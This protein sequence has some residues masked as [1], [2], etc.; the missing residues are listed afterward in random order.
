MNTRPTFEDRIYERV[1][2]QIH[3]WDTKQYPDIYALS[4]LYS[5]GFAEDIE[6]NDICIEAG[7]SVSF[8]TLSHYQSQIEKASSAQEAKWNFAFWLQKPVIEMPQF[9]GGT[10]DPEDWEIYQAWIATQNVDDDEVSKTL[11]DCYA[12][13]AKRLHDEGILTQTLC[14]NIPI[15]I[16]DLE[17]EELGDTATRWANPKALL[18]EY[19]AEW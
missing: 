19:L 16:H 2:N 3:S 14:R 4:F 9:L 18:I 6:G 17:Y 11:V 10:V 15:I 12:A 7:L 8:N 13:I 5:T 1:V